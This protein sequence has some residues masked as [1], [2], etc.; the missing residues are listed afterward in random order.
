MNDLQFLPEDKKLEADKLETLSKL[1][2]DLAVLRGKE[3]ETK[4]LLI[5]QQ[6]EN[7]F[8]NIELAT[9]D[10]VLKFF[11][12]RERKLSQEVIPAILNE[13]NLSE[14]V[15]KNGKKITVQDCVKASITL[16]NKKLAFINM[17]KAE[18]NLGLDE[19]QALQ[20]I[21]SLFKSHLEIE[22]NEKAMQY[23]LD[24]DITYDT[25][26]DIHWAT[27]NKY[28]KEHLEAG[29]NIPDGIFC[30]EYQKTNLK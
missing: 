20:N 25:K 3:S 9:L 18:E 5:I 21:N 26:R 4:V 22:I 10:R 27:L 6:L 7:S 11:K 29:Q 13:C 14:I 19:K 24:N 23:L 28:C 8:E 12:E 30:F 16:D 15:L 17:V 1:S 2:F